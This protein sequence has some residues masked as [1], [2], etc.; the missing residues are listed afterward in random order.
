MKKNNTF[1]LVYPSPWPIISGMMAISLSFGTI[2]LFHNYDSSLFMA[3][4]LNLLMIMMLWWRDII[5]ESTF[6]GLHTLKVSMNIRMGMLLFITSEVFLFMSLFWSFFFS[7]LSPNIE[8]GM[9]WPPKEVM[10]FNP[11][12]IPLLNTLILVSS[13]I[14]VTW[15]HFSMINNNYYQTMISLLITIMLG[16]YFTILQGFEYM[17]A[18]FCMADSILGSTFF[19]TTGMHGMHVM[20]GN[21]LLTTCLLRHMKNHFSSTHNVGFES[22]IWYWHFVDVVWLFLY[23]SMYWWSK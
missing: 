18:K 7:S 11:M 1:H 16:M 20:I 14:T 21:I 4:L 3:S 9:N 13:G 6:Q 5:R 17:E 15:S 12:Q 23:I 2:N 19:M 10:M 22:A 8:L